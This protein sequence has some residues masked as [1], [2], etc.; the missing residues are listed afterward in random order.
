MR[1]VGSDIV[2]ALGKLRAFNMSYDLL[3]FLW[4]CIVGSVVGACM[5]QWGRSYERN[6]RRQDEHD[7]LWADAV[8][9]DEPK[10]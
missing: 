4:D 10:F 3:A 5:F 6:K 7:K 8:G 1:E 9:R 2:I